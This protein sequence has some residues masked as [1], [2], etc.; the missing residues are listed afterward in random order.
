MVASICSNKLLNRRVE[1][2]HSLE[3][4]WTIFPALILV[5]IAFPSLRILYLIDEV[6]SPKLTIK[7]LGR[8]W[9]WSY[10]Y[11]DMGNLEFDSFMV[12]ESEL[13]NGALR[14]LEVDHHLILPVEVRIRGLVTATDVIHA[15]TLPSLGVKLDA[16]PGR[17]NQTPLLLENTGLFYGQCSEICGANHSFIPICV[18]SVPTN[19]FFN[20][21]KSKL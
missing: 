3:I 7:I 5:L 8:Q 14:L 11:P 18:E 4:F 1:A 12:P 21:V 10:E 6:R 19:Y 20:W 2:N 17:L 16:V 13:E 9:Y 15:W